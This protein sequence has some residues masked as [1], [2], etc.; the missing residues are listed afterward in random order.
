MLP[1][2]L[3]STWSLAMW[4]SNLKTPYRWTTLRGQSS[5]SGS[6]I[7][8][9]TD[10]S[11]R[12]SLQSH[13]LPLS[14]VVV[15]MAEPLEDCCRCFQLWK[16]VALEVWGVDPSRACSIPHVFVLACPW[17]LVVATVALDLMSLAMTSPTLSLSMLVVASPTS[18]PFYHYLL[19]TIPRSAHSS[20]LRCS[21]WLHCCRWY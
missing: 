18:T 8:V 13:P 2:L 17:K 6:W 21:T 16:I 10:S 11:Q 5:R 9:R 14:S 19:T 20:A 1:P 7:S 4:A 15:K 12:A 3:A